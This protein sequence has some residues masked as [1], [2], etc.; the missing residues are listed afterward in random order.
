MEDD[1]Q[2]KILQL[3]NEITHLKSLIATY[4]TQLSL[5]ND[6]ILE[7]N[8]KLSE[9]GIKEQIDEN[10]NLRNEKRQLHDVCLYQN[11]QIQ[12]Y[13]DVLLEIQQDILSNKYFAL[14]SDGRLLLFEILNK[15][16]DAIGE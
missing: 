1:L 7:L 10:I 9:K 8:Y 11:Q 6:E 4:N 12:Y 3:N 2:D 16:T 15:V 14:D 5:T 13:K